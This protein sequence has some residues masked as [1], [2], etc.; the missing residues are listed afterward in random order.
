M[1]D[2]D[3]EAP[4][5]THFFAREVQRRP[6]HV[7]KDALDLR[8]PRRQEIAGRVGRKE[9]EI[10]DEIEAAIDRGEYPL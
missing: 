7:R 4:G 1:V 5:M 2:F 9:D 10:V 8:N 6:A 3:L